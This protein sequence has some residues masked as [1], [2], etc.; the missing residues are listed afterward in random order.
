MTHNRWKFSVPRALKST[1][2]AVG[3][4][5]VSVGLWNS[6]LLDD[7]PLCMTSLLSRV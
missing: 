5:I 4:V 2:I 3:L 7:F 6:Q 1:L